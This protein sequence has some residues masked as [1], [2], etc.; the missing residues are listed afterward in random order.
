MH[1]IDQFLSEQYISA[2]IRLKARNIYATGRYALKKIDI[3]S[4]VAHYTVNSESAPIK[5]DLAINFFNSPNIEVNCSCPSNVLC[6]H[7]LAVLY[8]LRLRIV[9]I[10]V[11]KYNQQETFVDGENIFLNVL[12]G[13]YITM[14]TLQKAT[15]LFRQ[16]NVIINLAK[17]GQ[18]NATVKDEDNNYL[19]LITE[20]KDRQLKTSCRCKHTE[21]ALCPH[22]VATL[23]QFKKEFGDNGFAEIRNYEEE[24]KALLQQYG[25]SLKDDTKDLFDF[26]IEKGDLK[27]VLKD[28]GLEKV[29]KHAEWKKYAGMFLEHPKK[30]ILKQNEHSFL[31]AYVWRLPDNE[32]YN[33]TLRVTPIYGKEKKNGKI[34]AP[35]KEID[36]FALEELNLSPEDLHLYQALYILEEEDF[37]SEG[38]SIDFQE[39]NQESISYERH[40]TLLE[41]AHQII[42]GVYEQLSEQANY[43]LKEHS[44]ITP[45]NLIAIQLSHEVPVLSFQLVKTKAFYEL[46]VEITINETLIPWE[47]LTSIGYGFIKEADNNEVYML[48]PKDA[49]TLYY[50]YDKSSIKVKASEFKGFYNDFVIPLMKKHPVNFNDMKIA[51]EEIEGKA[52]RRLYVKE[53]DNFLLLIPAFRYQH[54]EFETEVE[55][56]NGEGI[57]LENNGKSLLIRR[58]K[59]TEEDTHNFLMDLH[60]EFTGQ[61]NRHYFYLSINKVLTAN[62]FFQAFERIHEQKIEVMGLKTLSKIKYNP[63]RPKM[64]MKAS[65]GTDWFDLTIAVNF[66]QQPVKLQDIRRAILNNDQFVKLGDGTLG[67]L[68]EEWLKKYANMFRIGKVKKDSLQLSKFQH[69]AIEEFY[70]EINNYEIL[71]ELQQKIEK[72]KTFRSIK[73]VE[74]PANVH[75]VLRNYQLEGFNWLRFLH[76]FGWGGCL[77]DDMGL[78]KTV[79]VLTFIQSLVNE[80]ASTTVLVVVPRSLVFNWEKEAEKFCP[81]LKL[82]IHSGGDRQ[83]EIKEFSQYHI[84]LTTY[85][86]VRN[87]IKML[88]EF[89]FDYVVLDESQAIKNPTSLVSKAVKLL[90]TSNR[91]IMTG[92]PIENNTFDLYAQ[93]DFL[94]PGMLG[95]ME[96]FRKEYANKI[97]R[98]RD[99]E[100]AV[101][102]QRLINPFILSRKKE[103]VAKELPEKTETVLYCELGPKQ[104]KTYDYFKNKYYEKIKSIIA[105]EG[106]GKSGMYVLQGLLKLRQICNSTALIKEEGDF[107]K[108]SIK[109]EILL[110]ELKQVVAHGGKALVFSY[111]VEM[112][113]I[114]R[115]ELEGLDIGYTMLTGS[116]TN[117]EELVNDFKTNEK[118]QIFLI[119]LKAGGFGLNLTEANYVFMID[120]WWNPAVEQQAIDRTHR[121][122]QEQ[123]VFAYKLICKNTIEEKIL[124]LQQKKQAVAK[125][126]ITVEAGFMKKLKEE[127]LQAL[128]S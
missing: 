101:E 59:E 95:S 108:E 42:G 44:Y 17:D 47:N 105:E 94:N 14:R 89:D 68:P 123:K 4:E 100:K 125:D 50:F 52:I 120:P 55:M 112:L 13:H 84:I 97:D 121:I 1:Y 122:G 34:G 106:I 61:R 107:G 26:K 114:V 80:K 104:R 73:Q 11:K 117:R 3:K 85:S 7:I 2:A 102:L 98:D 74:P 71:E 64:L 21:A 58:D 6:K 81:D 116:S 27:L 119:S 99:K 91:L 82:H 118:S 43:L 83:R 48:R 20:K 88:R 113:E 110:D 51:I 32:S 41:R 16:Q 69:T 12:S 22:K 39:D 40:F 5:Y 38:H 19:V 23:L 29:G 31:T 8:D 35:L 79:Q 72:L 9:D 24:K 111:F 109:L 77:A 78:G 103:E 37:S 46:T 92:T 36:A 70:K 56:D 18:V 65:S 90:N 33:P 63:F 87:D 66:G 60:P 28:P 93:M 128:F 115:H 15:T 30:I 124:E 75:A 54:G 45:G 96:Y 49:R 25:Y 53:M 62:W 76:E 86:L 10:P 57:V 127:D 126:I 67:I